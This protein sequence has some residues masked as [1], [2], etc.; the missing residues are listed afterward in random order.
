MPGRKISLNATRSSLA[1]E[2]QAAGRK[3]PSSAKA[4]AQTASL[5]C[6]FEFLVPR[7]L[8]RFELRLV[9]QLRIV[10]EPVEADY[11]LAKIGEADREGIDPGEFFGER[12]PDV[13]RVCPLHGVTSCALAFLS[14]LP[15]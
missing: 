12:D 6:V 1:R 4:D 3:R 5:L 9:R 7:H 13:L 2:R 14:D 10:V 15:S 11:L 8:N